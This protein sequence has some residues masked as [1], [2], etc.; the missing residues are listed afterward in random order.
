M[1]QQVYTMKLVVDDSAVRALEQRLSKIMGFGSNTSGKQSAGSAGST[2]NPFANLGKLAGIATGIAALVIAVQKIVEKVVSSSP[3]LQAM[4]KIL[5][6]SITLILRPIGDFF[7]FFLKP[8]LIMFLRQVALPFYKMS[9]PIMRWL[10]TQAGNAASSNMQSNIQGTWALL[11]GDWQGVDDAM[12][13]ARGDWLTAM[14]GFSDFFDKLK[15]EKTLVE[16]VSGFYKFIKRLDIVG[17]LTSVW[18]TFSNFFSGLKIP[19]ILKTTWDGFLGFITKL[20]I[21]DVIL[22]IWRDFKVFFKLIQIPD[23][24][25]KAWLGF[26]TFI[27]KLKIPDII[28]KIIDEFFGFIK[29]IGEWLNSIPDWIKSIIGI[30]GSSSQPSSNSS[31]TSQPKLEINIGSMLND[32]GRGLDAEKKKVLDWFNSWMRQ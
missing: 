9:A 26:T 10:G 28:S 8:I 11:T 22:N 25:T 23:W 16:T 6:M 24:L 29:K 15:I 21:P 27:A 3:A 13:K 7:A 5:D 4:L 17:G 20:K 2:A 19:D 1:S 30:G 32:A 14:Q 31:P 18:H 12:N